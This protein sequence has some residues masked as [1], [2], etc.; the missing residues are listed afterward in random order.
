MPR[1]PPIFKVCFLVECALL[2]AIFKG[3]SVGLCSSPSVAIDDAYTLGGNRICVFDIAPG[4]L[5]NDN[6][7]DGDQLTAVLVSGLSNGT[8]WLA[9]DGGFGYCRNPNFS[10]IDQFTYQASDGALDSNFAEEEIGHEMQNRNVQT[11]S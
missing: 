1:I 3:S 11:I 4:V 10:G 7:A 6:D 5:R 2:I 9:A 8:L